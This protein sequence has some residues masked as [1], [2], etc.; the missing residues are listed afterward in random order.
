[1]KREGGTCKFFEG[2]KQTPP[3]LHLKS[4]TERNREGTK[5]VDAGTFQKKVTAME[6]VLYRVAL[7]H[8]RQ[9]QDA[10][11]AVQEA[12]ALAW[13]KRESL[14]NPDQFSGWLYRIVVNQC[15][16]TL[17]R[18]KRFSFYPLQE[19][20]AVQQPQESDSVKEAMEKLPPDI[21][22]LM[23]LRY[24]DGYAMWEIAE[25]LGL[26][27]GTVSTRLSRGRKKLKEL[28]SVDWEDET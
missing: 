19:D 22:T 24:L 3:L 8:L 6:K 16:Q 9:M 7:S 14:R 11:D 10:E 4:E 27:L 23:M 2:E 5:K 25:A 15:R 26:P 12:I 28:L 1:M 17:R 21:R 20:T 18:K 13:E